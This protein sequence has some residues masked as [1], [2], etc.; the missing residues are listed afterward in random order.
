[1]AM[2]ATYDLLHQAGR[3]MNFNTPPGFCDLVI[4]TA[5]PKLSVVSF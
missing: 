3:V 5:W 1:M 2:A 4:V